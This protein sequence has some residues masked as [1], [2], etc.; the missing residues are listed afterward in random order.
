MSDL[1]PYQEFMSHFSGE[2]VEPEA[3]ECLHPQARWEAGRGEFI[4]TEPSCEA[5]LEM[6]ELLE[7]MAPE[8][9]K[10]YDIVIQL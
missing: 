3:P 1:S 4:C 8:L 5:V 7:A 2:I 10:P 6:P 9:Q